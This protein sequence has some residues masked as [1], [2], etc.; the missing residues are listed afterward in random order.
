MA[1]RIQERGNLKARNDLSLVLASSPQQYE[2]HYRLLFCSSR[3]TAV[4]QLVSFALNL[5]ATRSRLYQIIRIDDNWVLVRLNLRLKSSVN[6][7][8]EPQP[9]QN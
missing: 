5:Y 6:M 2:R 9:M 4:P 1:E 8:C 7:L 3:A